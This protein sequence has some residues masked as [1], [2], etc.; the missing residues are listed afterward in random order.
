MQVL[1]RKDPY[2]FLTGNPMTQLAE[3]LL[4]EAEDRGLHSRFYHGYFSL[5]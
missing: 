3:A 2:Q 4:C 5:T 1:F